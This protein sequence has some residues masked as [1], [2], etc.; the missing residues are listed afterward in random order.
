MGKP[1]QR[2]WSGQ[3][4]TEWVS[5]GNSIVSDPLPNRWVPRPDDLGH[6]DFVERVFL[7]EVAASGAVTT[8]QMFRLTG[9]THSMVDR[10]HR[11]A[12][13]PTPA[14][15]APT[16]SAE[17]VHL[18]IQ[19]TRTSAPAVP[20]GRP[21]LSTVSPTPMPIEASPSMV[22]KW[23]TRTKES[24]G[25]DLA[26]HGLAYLGVLLFFVG[27]FGLVVF[28]FGDVA[29]NLRPAA[30]LVI[31]SAPFLAAALLLQRGAVMVGRAL[32]VAGGLVLP[33][34]VITTFLDGFAFPPELS[35]PAMVATL[36]ACCAA[37]GVGYA[38][39]SRWHPA[40][41]LRFLVAPMAWLTTAM[42]TLGLDREI[43]VGKGV[44]TPG[45]AQTAAIAACLVVTLVLA[46]WHPKAFLA[47]PTMT[48]ALPGTLV[49]G[50][51]AVL[52]WAAE[53]WPAG[54]VFASGALL[55]LALELLHPRLPGVVDLVEPLWW[56]A[57]GLALTPGLGVGPAAAV[58]A[59]GFL[60]LV[61]AA[62]TRRPSV[63]AVAVP[64]AGAFFALLAV[65]ADPRWAAA[66]YAA[67][68]GWAVL[69]RLA[70]FGVPGA[71]IGLDLAAAVLPA[72]FVAAL[73]VATSLPI[74]TAVAAGLVLLTTVPAIRRV[75]SRNADDRFWVF[76]WP[77][78]AS[79]VAVAAV[80]GWS[81][82][83][84]PNER[85]LLTISMVGLTIATGFGPIAPVWRVW[86]VLGLGTA[87]W[88]MA[89]STAGL[90]ATVRGTV[91]GI[92]ALALVLGA[93]LRRRSP[94]VRMT[95]EPT[96]A[97]IGLAGHLL[98]MA[99]LAATGLG[100]GAV[101][102]TGL[103]T[104]GWAVTTAF[105]SRDRSPVGAA[106][107]QV[108]AALRYLPPVFVALGIPFT[109]AMALDVS[110]WLPMGAPW[111]SAVLAATAVGYG[112]ASRLPAP[113]RIAATLVWGAF[114][115]GLGACRTSDPR[116][117]VIGLGALILAVLLVPA[118]RRVAVQTWVAWAAL[119]PMVGLAGYQWLPWFAALSAVEAASITLVAVGGALLIGAAAADL[120]FGPWEPRYVPRR[121][122]LRSPVVLGALEIVVGLL[123]ALTA[124][125]TVTAGWLTVVV[126][127]ISF[128]TGV[129]AAAGLLGGVAVALGWLAALLIIGPNLDSWPLIGLLVVT[130]L[131]VAAELLHRFV[132]DRGWWSRWDLP[133]LV[134]AA[135]IALT[136]L[137]A[138]ASRGPDPF[139]M[140]S[141]LLGAQCWAVAIRLRH[142]RSVLTA[143]G[144]VGT[145]L[146]L[147]GAGVAGPGWLALSLLALAVGL[148]VAAAR[149]D[150]MA[151]LLFAVSAAPVAVTAWISAMVWFDWTAQQAVDV[152][153]L[154]A[155]VMVLAVAGLA[156]VRSV[157]R[158]WVLIWGAAGVLGAAGAAALAVQGR[159]LPDQP[160]APSTPIAI[161]LALVAVA[162][163][164]AARPL[165]LDWLRDL[166][167]ISALG[168]VAVAFEAWDL[169]AA[170]R[171]TVLV[172]ISV[173][174]AVV[175]L[176]LRDRPNR[177]WQRP[178][179][180]LGAAAAAGAIAVA[181]S[182]LPDALLLV[183]GLAAAAVQAAA[184]GVTLGSLVVQ[185]FSPVLACAAWL[186]YASE[187]LGGN[188]QWSTM[189]I[190]L[191]MLGVVAL[192][193]HDRSLH[194]GN[195][196][197]PP[198]IALEFIGIGFLVGASFVQA[199]TENLLY[200]MVALAL[201]LLIA[202]WGMVTR[203]R[204][205]LAA[206]VAVG[207]AAL[208]L[209][210]AV[211]LVRLLPEL[212]TAA[213]WVLI[214]GL[215]LVILLI[216]TLFEKGRK[217][218]RKNVVRFE[219]TTADWE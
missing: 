98:A 44:A 155:G 36:T 162:L 114:F 73:G 41:G 32:E 106:L 116:A 194:D 189:P 112:I 15:P 107:A 80:L 109:V 2:L 31:A 60:L 101:T 30:E 7:P 140:T 1:V 167:V 8:E 14:G 118:H 183:P 218:V 68:S 28:A 174:G 67:A 97:G 203:V 154:G 99:S 151:R 142:R 156:W 18:P 210:V 3:N 182:Q 217:A 214:L 88:L 35:G 136:T 76:W 25:S 127:A 10:A 71:D 86:P 104:T 128:A 184:I 126:A 39:W 150:G 129:L 95:P 125:P 90:P 21:V 12:M 197:A 202:A 165:N 51:L 134:V 121:A 160:A 84:T 4:W 200:T 64:T 111:A 9:L 19:P 132:P 119:A 93:H 163:L 89:C 24:I 94:A 173:A 159:I 199:V 185:V 139:V 92:A 212:T 52:T 16:G 85:W 195:M 69:R 20:V 190:G 209:L 22:S 42:A 171:V 144:V 152:T 131:L 49:V 102:V 75:L 62:G 186:V 177:V 108:G 179:L 58:A 198:I 103:A 105:D 172:L 201:G 133:L 170:A 124:L 70:P 138:A 40:T 57:V 205:R 77:A 45:S 141:V 216:A 113:E 187:L 153:A 143:L 196:A 181:G 11:F 110:G 53:G 176:A 147:A 48:A 96:R 158:T 180:E 83:S 164:L 157:D 34:M 59:L 82:V 27:A 175:A 26:V 17:Q 130:V 56:A 23:W 37:I 166:S 6:L 13:A 161:G 145:G 211:P 219:Q 169:P 29:P 66:V 5:D 117:A 74:A 188:P 208:V 137:D 148:T 122:A 204:R 50:V 78:A 72:G 146:V 206:G 100:W 47:A 120:R 178:V 192:L 79:L 63:L 87:A 115:A 191:A 123:V 213:L 193:R 91:L 149:T 65:W 207:L 46:R 54:Q 81:T 38:L 215:G 168:A 135:P 33:V 43:P 61:E 55:L